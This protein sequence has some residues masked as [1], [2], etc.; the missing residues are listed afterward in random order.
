MRISVANTENEEAE[1]Y[2]A[3]AGDFAANGSRNRRQKLHIYDEEV[4]W[5]GAVGRERRIWWNSLKYK[6]STEFVIYSTRK[7]LYHNCK[8]SHCYERNVKLD[9]T[10][11]TRGHGPSP[12]RVNDSDP[13]SMSSTQLEIA[14]HLTG[15]SQF[16]PLE[17]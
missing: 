17:S 4:E 15:Q 9:T 11:R 10:T 12:T 5:S 2:N 3:T 6:L 8:R 16:L 7:V 1:T 14:R 13:W